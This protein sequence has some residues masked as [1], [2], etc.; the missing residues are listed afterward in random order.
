MNNL[1]YTGW[2][3]VGVVPEGVQTASIN[4]FRYYIIAT[5][6]ILLMM[7]LIVNKMIA[8]KISKPIL[9]LD[10]SVKSYETGGKAEIYIGD[11]SKIKHLSIH[12]NLLPGW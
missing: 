6:I 9:K 1:S 11:T 10:E 3:L 5:T 7:L 2:K 4:K 8:R 12:W